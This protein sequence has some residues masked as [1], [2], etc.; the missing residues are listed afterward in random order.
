MRTLTSEATPTALSAKLRWT[1]LET[2]RSRNAV[3]RPAARDPHKRHPELRAGR[4]R[5]APRSSNVHAMPRMVFCD[6]IK[7]SVVPISRPRNSVKGDHHDLPWVALL[8]SKRRPPHLCPENH[9]EGIGMA[10]GSQGFAAPFEGWC[11]PTFWIARAAPEVDFGGGDVLGTSPWARG[12][13]LAI[14]T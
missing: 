8:D 5:F 6:D 14:L 7:V 4:D 12:L 2:H 11:A 10:A 1:F 3:G 9:P 13:L